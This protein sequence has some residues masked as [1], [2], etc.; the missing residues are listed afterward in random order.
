MA[1]RLSEARN[2]GAAVACFVLKGISACAGMTVYRMRPSR[3]VAGTNKTQ[4]Q[5]KFGSGE[6]R[7][8]PYL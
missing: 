6:A 1:V 7:K 4:S 2:N 8:E 3:A 5:C